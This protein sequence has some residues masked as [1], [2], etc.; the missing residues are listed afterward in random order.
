MTPEVE[1]RLFQPFG[2]ADNGGKGLGLGLAGVFGAVRQLSGWIEYSTDVGV[3]TEFRVFLP[4][5]PASEVLASI[6]AQAATPVTRGTVLLVEPEDRVRSLARCI[7]NWNEYKVVEAEDSGTALVLWDN[8]GPE[9]DLLLTDI[10]LPGDLSG[11]DLASHLQKAKPDLQVIYTCGAS[12]ENE[13]QVPATLEGL[14]LLPKPY[15]PG[16]LIEVVQSRLI[17]SN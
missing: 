16:K 15:T 4:T 6:Q 14:T 8:Q 10:N 2:T 11:R 5:A 7:L 17:R 1:S 13:R 12:A 3:G 9:I